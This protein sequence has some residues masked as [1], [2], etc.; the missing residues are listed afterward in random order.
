MENAVTEIK[1]GDEEVT[2][3]QETKVG[4]ISFKF[5]GK[6]Y[7]CEYSYT[8]GDDKCGGYWEDYDIDKPKDIDDEDWDIIE[9]EL[10][11]VIRK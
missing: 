5:K 11:D 1:K 2:H 7:D 4:T 6:D 8:V 3:S 10:R 9:D